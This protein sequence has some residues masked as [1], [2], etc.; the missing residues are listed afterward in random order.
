MASPGRET[1]R[2]LIHAH[3]D[4]ALQRAQRGRFFTDGLEI[5]PTRDSNSGRGGAA[6]SLRQ[7][8]LATLGCK[9]ME[10]PASKYIT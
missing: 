10:H 5:H 1:L 3:K 8:G 9:N 7:T 4:H 2:I 6:R